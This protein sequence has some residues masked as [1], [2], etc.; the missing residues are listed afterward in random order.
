MGLG[1]VV[2]AVLTAG[3]SYVVISN[4]DSILDLAKDFTALMI[5]SEI[6]NQ[7]ADLSKET[8]AVDAIIDDPDGDYEELFKIEITTSGTASGAHNSLCDKD[9]ANKALNNRLKWESEQLDDKENPVGPTWPK[10]KIKRPK[11]ISLKYRKRCSNLGCCNLFLYTIY[12]IHRMIFVSL[13]FYY[14]PLIVMVFA[15]VYPVIKHWN[16]YE[17]REI[18]RPDCTD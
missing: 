8:I 13:W 1:Q 6:D 14:L 7:F 17:C 15:N 11:H 12:K 9:P 4:S 18:I 10:G 5:I 3:V 2:S 16:N